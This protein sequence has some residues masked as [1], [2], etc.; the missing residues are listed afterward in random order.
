M[1]RFLWW[2]LGPLWRDVGIIERGALVFLLVLTAL[3]C[4]L[5]LR[6]VV[7]AR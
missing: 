5:A 7:V 6:A 3:V 4:L 1:K 2:A